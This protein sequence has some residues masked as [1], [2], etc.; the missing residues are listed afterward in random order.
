M[1]GFN[2]DIPNQAQEPVYTPIQPTQA[3][4]MFAQNM[5][6]YNIPFGQGASQFLTG[7]M[8]IPMQF[9][10]DLPSYQ[11]TPFLPGDFA[12]FIT[13]QATRPTKKESTVKIPIFNPATGTYTSVSVAGGPK[14]T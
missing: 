7:Q 9:G 5:T 2:F 3:P 1:A 4:A 14:T 13:T 11:T 12:S 6:P 8:A 10:V